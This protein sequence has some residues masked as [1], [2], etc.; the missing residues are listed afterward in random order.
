VLKIVDDA[1]L[2]EEMSDSPELDEFVLVEEASD[3]KQAGENAER[4]DESIHGA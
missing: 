4:P 3:E 1:I 2:I